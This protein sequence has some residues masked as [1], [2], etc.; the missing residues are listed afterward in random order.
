MI[1]AGLTGCVSSPGPAERRRQSLDEHPL[2]ADIAY[3]SIAAFTTAEHLS[4]G[5]SVPWQ[6]LAATDRRNDG[7]VLVEDAVIPGSTLL[8]YVNADHWDIAISIERQMPHLSARASTRQFPCDK[9]LDAM[10]LFVS[11]ALNDRGR[12][13]L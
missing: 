9:L 11:E 1:L 12:Q 5:L 4:R 6:L 7:Q 3:F 2:P 8:G 13:A 10:L